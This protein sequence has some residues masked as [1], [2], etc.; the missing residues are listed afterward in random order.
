MLKKV[1]LNPVGV[2]LFVLVVALLIIILNQGKA[3]DKLQADLVSVGNVLIQN[4]VAIEAQAKELDVRADAIEGLEG[5]IAA[6]NSRLNYVDSERGELEANLVSLQSQF[7]DSAVS[8]V[9]A[10]SNL[11]LTVAALADAKANPVCP[12]CLVCSVCEEC[13]TV[14]TPIVETP[15]TE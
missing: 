10:N 1:K 12:T 8:L 3:N 5:E 13:P 9:E 6:V 4:D 7:N 11:E 15:V 14:E 2:L